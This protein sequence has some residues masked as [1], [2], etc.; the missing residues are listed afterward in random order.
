MDTQYIQTKQ[1]EEAARS[2]V[3]AAAWCYA[4]SGCGNEQTLRANIAAFEHLYIRPR[5]LVPMDAPDLSTTVLGTSISLPVMAAPVGFQQLWHPEGERASVQGTGQAQTLYVASSSA[6]TSLEEIAGRV[7]SP[8]WF[9]L[10]LFEPRSLSA[11]LV[12]RAQQAGYQAIVV[13]VDTP[14]YGRKERFWRNQYSL[15]EHIRKANFSDDVDPMV[16]STFD[17]GVF[18]WLRTLTDL[19]L[20]VKGI[21][22]AEDTCKAIE[23]GV[24]AI[25]VSNHGGRQLDAALPSIVALPEVV[26]AARGEV[27]VYLDGGIRTGTDVFKALASGA[28]AVFIGRSL[29][30]GLAVQGAEGV[31]QIFA[32]LREELE[33]AMVLSGCPDVNCITSDLLKEC[34]W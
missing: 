4:E 15:P 29:L 32:I 11:Q 10:Y 26:G 8:L 1:Y 6:T 27:E 30:W 14:Y 2:L 7:C 31:N 34:N 12:Q 5:M 28:R 3:D 24:A 18:D 33:Y 22:T 25:V 13:T 16:S 20:I 21:L 17:W 9:Q 23:H 19:P